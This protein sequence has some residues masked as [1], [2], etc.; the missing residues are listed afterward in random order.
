[1]IIS[2]L[3]LWPSNKILPVWPELQEKTICYK[4]IKI[5]TDETLKKGGNKKKKIK[6]YIRMQEV[7]L[8]WP[9]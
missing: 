8:I 7:N 5:L 6:K 4:L 2:F 1:M 3:V 9:R